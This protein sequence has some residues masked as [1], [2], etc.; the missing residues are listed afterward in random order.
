M[1][2]GYRV[3]VAFSWVMLM[4]SLVPADELWEY[5]NEVWLIL[6][7]LSAPVWLGSGAGIGTREADWVVDP[8]FMAGIG[9]EAVAWWG[10]WWRVWCFTKR[11]PALEPRPAPL[12]SGSR[13]NIPE[14]T[15][16]SMDVFIVGWTKWMVLVEIVL[17]HSTK[18]E[19][20]VADETYLV[21][22]KRGK[23]QWVPH[24]PFQLTKFKR[25]YCRRA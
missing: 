12:P 20:R 2:F 13:T 16:T 15:N 14:Y 5:W 22:R 1:L 7:P 19:P 11:R 10:S 17:D 8:V 9:P 25:C 6:V 21:S 24:C 18:L 3:A 23:I 4:D